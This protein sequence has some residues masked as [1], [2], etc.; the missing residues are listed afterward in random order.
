MTLMTFP[1]LLSFEAFPFAL[2]ISLS[3]ARIRI[4]KSSNAHLREDGLRLGVVLARGGAFTA[5][6]AITLAGGDRFLKENAGHLSNLPLFVVG[7]FA[8]VVCEVLLNRNSDTT[9]ILGFIRFHMVLLFSIFRLRQVKS[10]TFLN[11]DAKPC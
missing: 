2:L 10:V 9:G 7:K 11:G 6:N 8:D 3:L 5:R 1:F 4:A